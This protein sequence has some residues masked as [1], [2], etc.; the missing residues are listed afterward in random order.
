MRD[1]LADG[2]RWLR[3][4]VEEYAAQAI[5]YRRGTD[6]LN[7]IAARGQSAHTA[8]DEYGVTIEVTTA[9]WLFD[10][11]RLVFGGAIVKPQ[12]GDLIEVLT[13]GNVYAYTVLPPSSGQRCYRETAGHLRV[14]TKESDT[15]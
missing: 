12:P 11:D 3:G 2:A 15:G 9:D 7:L 5:V 10:A 6:A 14:Y 8:T 4:V 13:G 1:M